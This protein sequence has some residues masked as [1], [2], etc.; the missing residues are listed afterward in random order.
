MLQPMNL[1]RAFDGITEYWSPV[2]IGRVNDQYLK[3][4]KIKGEFCWHAHDDEDELF[5][6]VRGRLTMMFEHRSVELGEGDFLT[7]PKG[8]R[9]NPVAAEECWVL[10]IET[11]TTRHTGDVVDPRTKSI[12]AQL[13]QV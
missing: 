10:L 11:V 9:H 1:A 13:G 4:A 12:E 5:Y 3:A 8:V 2:V 6:I 7:V